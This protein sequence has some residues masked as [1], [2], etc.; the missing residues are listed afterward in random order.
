MASAITYPFQCHQ[1]D[2]SL[3]FLLVPSK[4]D[5]LL[6]ARLILK[7][8]IF[9][10][11]EDRLKEN[12]L[13]CWFGKI[14]THCQ[15]FNSGNKSFEVRQISAP[16]Q[17]FPE[18]LLVSPALTSRWTQ[19]PMPPPCCCHLF[20]FLFFHHFLFFP[21]QFYIVRCSQFPGGETLSY[22]F[23]FVWAQ[24]LADV[25]KNVFWFDL[26]LNNFSWVKEVILPPS[27]AINNH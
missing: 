11:K 14:S 18:W 9:R 20:L 25:S 4:R 22:V 5:N 26:L 24:W 8:K 27:L 12:C 21:L 19:M 10:G 3:K 1:T 17:S 23:G 6:K 7:K 16:C 2:R 13:W 15:N